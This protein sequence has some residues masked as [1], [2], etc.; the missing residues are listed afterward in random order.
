MI[1][2]R[3]PLSHRGVDGVEDVIGTVIGMIGICMGDSR[4]EAGQESQQGEL[5]SHGAVEER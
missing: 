5:D 2:R 3:A 1:S 4:R